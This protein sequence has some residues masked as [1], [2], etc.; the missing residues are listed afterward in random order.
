MDLIKNYKIHAI[1][2]TLAP[3]THM[4]GTSGNEGIINR[5]SV[6]SDGRLREVPVLSGNAIRHKVIREPGA[7]FLVK[8]LGL[9][10]KLSIAQAN[11][12][13]NGGSLTESSIYDNIKQIN[14]MQTLFPLFRLLGGCLTNQIIGGSL[15]VLRGILVCEE[16]RAN[17]KDLLPEGFRL[18]Q[19]SLKSCEDFIGKYQYTRGDASKRKDSGTIL[20]QDP[21]DESNLMIY[22]GQTVKPGS[23][24]HHGFVL[25][26][27]S[28]LEVGAL[29]HSLM[30][31]DEGGA[32]IGGQSRIGHGQLKTDIFFEDNEDF[33]GLNVDAFDCVQQYLNHIIDNKKEQVDWLNETFN[34]EAKK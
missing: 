27:V 12:L 14:K 24:F 9:I 34:H 17:L 1:S 3:I 11:F 5:E 23:V 4:R 22:S 26:N 21:Q 28:R 15:I 32:L 2:T 30:Q 6:I 31:W 7:Y 19:E 13:F 20:E 33:Y 25:Q 29:L 18:P 8:Q 10:G 16:N